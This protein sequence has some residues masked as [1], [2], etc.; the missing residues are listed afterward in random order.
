M[1]SNIY[2]M[3]CLRSKKGLTIRPE[4]WREFIKLRLKGMFDSAKEKGMY[5]TQHPCGDMSKIFPDLIEL[6]LDIYNITTSYL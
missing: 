3:G 6:G 4:L 5:V 1:I 2:S